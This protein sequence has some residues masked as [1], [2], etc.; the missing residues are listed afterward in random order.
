MMSSL[1]LGMRPGGYAE[2][3]AAAAQSCHVLPDGMTGEQAALV[4][5]YAVALHAVRRSKAARGGV[6]TAAVIGAGPIGL[7]TL[8]ALQQEGVEA[9]AVAEMSESRAAMAEHMGATHVVSAAGKLGSVL[10]EAPEVVFDCAGVAATAPLA[11]EAV[12]TA[13]QVVL[14]G[15]VNPGDMLAMPGTLWIIKEVDVLSSLAYTDDEFA[16]AVTAVFEGA[17]DP[18][19]VVSDIRPL[20]AAEA[21]FTELTQPGGPVKILLAPTV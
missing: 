16:E 2:L 1:G 6:K 21:S 13:G 5:P 7:F 19:L 18:G 3:V 8:A 14:V 9:I 17:V 20:D 11:L 10:G 15:V 4:E 12:R